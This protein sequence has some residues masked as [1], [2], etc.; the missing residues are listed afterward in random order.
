MVDKILSCKKQFQL[1]RYINLTYAC[2]SFEVKTNL[3]NFAKYVIWLE[4]FGLFFKIGEKCT[5][6]FYNFSNC[7]K[8][9]HNVSTSQK[10]AT[11][12][13]YSCFVKNIRFE[14]DF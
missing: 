9:A 4:F 7:V 6:R 2:N 11:N 14:Y 10:C 8:N 12:V 3:C 13:F 5:L 1:I